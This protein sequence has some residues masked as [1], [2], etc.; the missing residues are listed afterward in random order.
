[1]RI[2]RNRRKNATARVFIR[3]GTGKIDIRDQVLAPLAITMTFQ[4][5]DIHATVTGGGTTGQSEAIRIALAKAL[6]HY[7]N[8]YGPIL[9]KGR[10]SDRC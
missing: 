7:Q 10:V 6:E 1:M 9:S 8:T 5:Y 2:V 4:K 3:K